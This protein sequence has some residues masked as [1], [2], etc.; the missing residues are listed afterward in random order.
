E[1]DRSKVA[2]NEP[3][4]IKYANNEKTVNGK[5]TSIAEMNNEPEK[6][7]K[8]S[9]VTYNFTA[10][11]D[12]AIPVGYSVELLIP[13]NEIH[14]PLKSVVEKDGEYFV[15][16]VAKNKAQKQ[17]VTVEKGSGYYLLHDGL[18]EHDK[19]IKDAK[20]VKDGMDVTV[21]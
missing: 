20:S 12:E 15:Y 9:L 4:E 19:I 13:R 5:V 7:E 8:T 16:T 6:E 3:I 14:L 17:T 10:V 1:Y 18:N 21:E 11:P 2:L